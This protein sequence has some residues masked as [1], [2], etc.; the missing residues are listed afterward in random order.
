MV[1]SEDQDYCGILRR[2]APDFES[3][4]QFLQKRK[5]LREIGDS[6]VP[7]E[8]GMG[9]LPFQ[10]KKIKKYKNLLAFLKNM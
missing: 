8:R 5:G 10:M 7:R 9:H 2:I 6:P 3:P 4:L 1:E